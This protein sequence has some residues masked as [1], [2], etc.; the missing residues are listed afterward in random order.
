M[1]TIR[2]FSPAGS[3]L[4]SAFAS[5][6]G[7]GGGR[8]HKCRRRKSGGKTSR[9]KIKPRVHSHNS[10]TR[11]SRRGG[12][13]SEQL[14]QQ[15]IGFHLKGQAG[16]ARSSAHAQKSAHAPHATTES[17]RCARATPARDDPR[18]GAETNRRFDRTSTTNEALSGPDDSW[19]RTRAERTARA[20]AQP[21]AIGARARRPL[22]TLPVRKRGE[23]TIW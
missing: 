23:R 20:R 1:A 4:G 18:R 8:K 2:A 19:G 22:E 14:R 21:M 15:L 3:A 7:S 12:V 9:N 5:G 16:P 6:L 13:Y 17:D 10:C 11:S